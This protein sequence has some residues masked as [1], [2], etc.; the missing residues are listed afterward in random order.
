M[1]KMTNK[2][3][4][5]PDEL[6]SYLLNVSAPEH[7]VLA[8]LRRTTAALPG[9]RMQIPPEQGAFMALLIRSIN[10]RRVLE[11]GVFTGYSTLSMALAL[12]SDGSITACDIDKENA[13]IARVLAS[14][15]RSILDR[16]E[17]SPRFGNTR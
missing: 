2:N 17:D 7:G 11:V 15:K 9:H 3:S 1:T 4:Y 12:P 8:A 13:D 6:R 14:S 16:F 10:A 5:V